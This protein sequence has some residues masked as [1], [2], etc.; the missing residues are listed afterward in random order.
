[1]AN[2]FKQ[3]SIADALFATNYQTKLAQELWL[4]LGGKEYRV[5]GKVIRIGRALDNDIVVDDK[6]CSRYHARLTIKNSEVLIEDL[7]SRNGIHVNG[8][9][10]QKAELQ[11]NDEIEI[12]DLKGIFFQREKKGT[13]KQKKRSTENTQAKSAP[14]GSTTV[15]SKSADKISLQERIS[16][17]PKP[18]KLAL[19]ASAPLLIFAFLI[20]SGGSST[21]PRA[22][23]SVVSTSL[24]E[25]RERS[26]VQAELSQDSIDECLEFEDLGNFKKAKQ[27]FETLAFTQEV[28]NHLTRVLKNQDRL[29][30]KRYQ[31]GVRA[32]E[33]YYYDLAIIKWQEVVLIAEEQSELAIKAQEGIE[34][35]ERNKLSL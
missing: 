15:E 14:L 23:A 5:V 29:V 3:N 1:M 7:K 32:F 17:L 13:K 6:S 20:F 34:S 24:E 26:V 31:E 35:A 19:A 28:K 33:N 4:N 8:K 10:L 30:K 9:R 22:Q 11:D 18:A 25:L 2:G 12:G 21:S 27:C 16:Q